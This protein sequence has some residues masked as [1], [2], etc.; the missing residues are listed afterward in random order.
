MGALV[1]LKTACDDFEV[2]FEVAPIFDFKKP[3]DER[4]KKI[5]EGI[6]SIDEM[7]AE[8][9]KVVDEL[10]SKIDTLTNNADTLDYIVAVCSGVVAGAI[11]VLFVEDFSLQ[12][13]N[14]IGNQKIDDKIIKAAKKHGYKGDDLKGAVRHLEDSFPQLLQTNTVLGFAIHFSFN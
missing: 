4:Q 11:D 5:L 8:N 2:E 12:N 9:Q 6:A 10:N 3:L 14:A 1:E 13:A 7:M